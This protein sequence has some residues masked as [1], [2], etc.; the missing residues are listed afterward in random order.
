[1]SS[2]MLPDENHVASDSV[3]LHRGPYQSS[4]KT[5]RNGRNAELLCSRSIAAPSHSNVDLPI[6]PRML[7]SFKVYVT[8]HFNTMGGARSVP[9]DAHAEA[10]TSFVEAH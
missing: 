2:R 8:D 4:A 3:R 9:A 5:D 7:S 10:S 1:M 6:T